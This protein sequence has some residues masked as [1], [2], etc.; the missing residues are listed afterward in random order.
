[1][2]CNAMWKSFECVLVFSAEMTWKFGRIAMTQMKENTRH[3]RLFYIVY[4]GLVFSD[5]CRPGNGV[6]CVWSDNFQLT[7]FIY[8]KKK[9]NKKP[10]QIIASSVHGQIWTMAQWIWAIL[11]NKRT[12]KHIG[13]KCHSKNVQGHRSVLA[14][15]LDVVEQEPKKKTCIKL[16][17]MLIHFFLLA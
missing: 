7:S 2:S 1:M 17:V 9:R 14:T 6:I 12:H 11:L 5:M 3:S 4:P 16:I 13:L 10:R 8:I 15:A